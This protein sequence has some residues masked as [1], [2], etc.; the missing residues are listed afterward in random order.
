[1]NQ[2]LFPK[3]ALKTNLT[4]SHFIQASINT[5]CIRISSSTVAEEN[6]TISPTA[7]KLIKRRPYQ[8]KVPFIVMVLVIIAGVSANVKIAPGSNVEQIFPR[9]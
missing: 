2:S 1:M 7:I 4:K 6:R 3:T 9:C 5:S 8:R